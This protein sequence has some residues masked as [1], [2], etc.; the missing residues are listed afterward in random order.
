M[1]VIHDKHG[2]EYRVIKCGSENFHRFNIEFNDCR[3]GYANVHFAGPEILHFDDLR[4]D[5]KAVLRPWFSW[6][7]FFLFVSFPPLRWRTENFQEREIGTEMIEFLTDYARSN[8]AQR[9]EGEVRYDDLKNNPDLENWYR[10]R[11][12]I[13]AGGKLTAHL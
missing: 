5:D 2:R 1:S 11:G 8:S 4:I 12:F 3:I 9:I 6:D 10:R 13:V 7:L